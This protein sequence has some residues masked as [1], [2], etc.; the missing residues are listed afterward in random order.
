MVPRIHKILERALNNS[1]GISTKNGD[2]KDEPFT[3]PETSKEN[4]S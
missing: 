2:K 4:R 1:L 3:A